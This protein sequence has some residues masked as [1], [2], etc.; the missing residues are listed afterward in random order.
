M[1]AGFTSAL[2]AYLSEP[3]PAPADPNAAT[4]EG[5]DPVPVREAAAVLA[6]Q[7]PQSA[8]PRF[9]INVL[10]GEGAQNRVTKGRARA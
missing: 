6:A 5:V 1:S 3:E 2:L 9:K 4:A 10:R 8:A 7:E